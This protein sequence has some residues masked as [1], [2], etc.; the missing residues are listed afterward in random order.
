MRYSGAG[1]NDPHPFPYFAVALLPWSLKFSVFGNFKDPRRL[2]R[3]SH[4]VPKLRA[5]IGGLV[6]KG[7]KQGIDH[8]HRRGCG[9]RL[10]S[11][12]C[13]SMT[14]EGRSSINCRPFSK[15]GLRRLAAYS[16]HNLRR[17][18]SGDSAVQYGHDRFSLSLH[19]ATA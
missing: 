13:H 15:G 12:V 2:R 14:S 18:W 10:P 6:G 5:A 7:R 9:H 1:R 16:T 11:L 8:L 19:L 17:I 4:S 3:P